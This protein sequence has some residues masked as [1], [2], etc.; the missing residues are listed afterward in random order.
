VRRLILGSIFAC[1]TFGEPYLQAQDFS[2]LG[3][4]V[5]IHGFVSQGFV[6]TNTN[7]WL[8]M[9]SNQGSAAFTDFG[10]NVSSNVAS[11]LRVGAQ[12][13]DYNLGQ[14]GQYHPSLDWALADYRVR[15]WFGIRGGKVKTVRGLFNDTQDLDFLHAFALLP[16]SIY[17]I[18][19]RDATI[20]HVGGDIYGDVPLK[21][22][23]DDLSYTVYAGHRSDSIYSGYPYLLSQF[24]TRF[25]RFGGAA[26]RRRLTLGYSV[27][28]ATARSIAHE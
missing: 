25:K 17:P 21:R 26:I 13:Y 3:R 22:G 8:T 28:G 15:S 19:T 20:A 2:L 18:D 5:E 24:G 27:E 12:I 9:N 23:R 16:Q 1:L 11:K 7:N 6:Y 14:L 4:E 10:F